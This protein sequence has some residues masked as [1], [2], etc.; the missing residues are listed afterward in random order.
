MTATA[1][2]FAIRV[3]VTD[4]WDHATLQVNPDM[5]VAEVK[6]EALTRTLVR[7]PEPTDAYQVKFRGALVQDERTT[8]RTLGVAPNAA[9]IVLPIKRRPA[10]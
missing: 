4:A 3:M 8:L 2:T 1:T 10:R 6:R 9:L 7:A 5:S